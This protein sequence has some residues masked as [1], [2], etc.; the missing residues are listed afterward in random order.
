[1]DSSPHNQNFA[2]PDPIDIAYYLAFLRTI[3]FKYYQYILAVNVLGVMAISLYVQSLSPSYSASVTLHIAPKDNTVFNLEQMYWGNT[4]S[5]FKETQ[6]GILKS[7]KLLRTVITEL[8]LHKEESLSASSVTVGFLGYLINKISTEEDA[9]LTSV[10]NQIELTV[11]ELNQLITVIEPDPNSYSNLVDVVVTMSRPD[12]AA[13][14]ANQLAESYINS[15]FMNEMETALKNQNFLSGRL[16]ILREQL[17]QA[18]QRLRDF[19]E[20]EDIVAGTSGRDEVDTELETV[21]RRYFTARQE[22]TILENL[23]QQVEDIQAGGTDIRNVRAIARDPIVSSI[24]SEIITLE[25]RKSELS[26]RY[27]R[28]HARMIAVNS[29]LESA[30]RTLRVQIGDVLGGIRSD[31]IVAKRIE[32]VAEEALSTVRNKK[33]TLGR[34][35]FTINDLQQDIDVKRDVYTIF[36]EKLN[37][38]DASGPV[39][40]TNLWIAD[41]ATVPRVGEKISW[42]VALV[43]TLLFCTILAFAIGALLIS[44][45][46]TLETEEE[47]LDKT[48]AQLL[49]LLPIIKGKFKDGINVP[50]YEYQENLHSRFS[51]AIRSIRTSLALINVN[52]EMRKILVTSS[53]INEGKSSVALTLSASASQTMKVLLIDADLRRPSLEKIVSD[54]THKMLGLSDVISGEVKLKDC[55]FHHEASHID[56]LTAG[57]RTL[58]PLELLGST[59]FTVLLNEVSDLYDRIV[60]DSPPATAVSDAYLLGSVVDTVIFVIKAGSTH[61]SKIRS[62]L[63]RFKQLNISVAGVIL[64]QVDFDSSHYPHYKNYYAYEGYGASDEPV[65]LHDA[66]K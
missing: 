12:L 8:E 10:E 45:D 51:E 42:W 9:P 24:R 30:N 11:E 44:I 1:M 46:N 16:T 62:V 21:T 60:I 28:R 31:L 15:V 61:V 23:I 17:Q 4:D 50:F 65:K 29:E 63:N 38:D 14:T 18:E 64:N 59:Q 66:S 48:G 25:Q 19:M 49:G 54:G 35:S 39:R 22:R 58:R 13:N 37:R 3:W 53:E 26:K 57:S 32:K 55:I 27:G 43:A 33:Q 36:L 52:Q 41:P 2:D 7:N 20:S 40:N 47:V 6:V 34:K 56:I 5:G